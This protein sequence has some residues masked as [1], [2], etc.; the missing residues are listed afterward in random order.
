MTETFLFEAER[1]DMARVARKMFERK[2][3]NVAANLL[4]AWH[5]ATEAGLH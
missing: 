4:L 1:R 3:T 5:F 2:M